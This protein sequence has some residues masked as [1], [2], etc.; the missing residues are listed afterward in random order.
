MVFMIHSIK[1][2]FIIHF[3]TILIGC[4]FGIL[5]FGHVGALLFLVGCF[6]GIL[7][8]ETVDVLLL[9]VGF[10][11]YSVCKLFYLWL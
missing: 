5:L 1:N 10:L 2:K 3:L 6:F 8:S 7:L 9:L 11:I 4:F